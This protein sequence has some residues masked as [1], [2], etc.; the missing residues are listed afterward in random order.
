MERSAL[1]KKAKTL[2]KFAYDTPQRNRVIGSPGHNSTVNWIK[3]T[4]EAYPDYYKVYLEP[5]PISVGV[6]ANLT[7]DGKSL[8]AFAL[9]IAPAGS[10]S[11]E[12]AVVA[13]LGCS[14]VGNPVYMCVARTLTRP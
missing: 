11:A 1:L 12:I 5:F 4:L 6:S 13:N 8:E 14:A 7:V 3:K 10:A 9:T 2:E